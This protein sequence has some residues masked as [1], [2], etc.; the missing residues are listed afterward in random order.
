MEHVYKKIDPIID[1]WIDRHALKLHSNM[2]GGEIRAVYVS[3]VSGETFQIWVDPPTDGKVC[4]NVVCIEGRREDTPAERL[5]TSFAE[6]DES[7]E[8]TYRVVLEWMAPS[9]RFFPKD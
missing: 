7:L 2:E 5:L 1:S 6:L 8:R 9:E 3:S 4:I